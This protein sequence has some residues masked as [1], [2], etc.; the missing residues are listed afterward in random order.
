M[1]HYV[2]VSWGINDVYSYGIIT[3]VETR[4]LH[5][6][7][8]KEG[9]K[10]SSKYDIEVQCIIPPILTSIKHVSYRRSDYRED[11]LTDNDESVYFQKFLEKKIFVLMGFHNVNNY[12]K[13]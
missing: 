13:V 2:S 12:P 10:F 6:Q 8:Q 1:T 7:Y 9:E 5:E 11:T 3:E 4:S